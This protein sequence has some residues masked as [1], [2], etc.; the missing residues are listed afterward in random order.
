M[1]K[2]Y[3]NKFTII[4]IFAFILSLLNLIADISF[5]VAWEDWLW[6]LI[7]VL[8]IINAFTSDIEC[9]QKKEEIKTLKEELKRR[10]NSG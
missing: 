10:R 4:A 9:S 6:N 5:K 7:A 3:L 2:K 8:W 1:K